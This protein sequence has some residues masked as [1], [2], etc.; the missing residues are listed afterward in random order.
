MKTVWPLGAQ[1]QVQ[2]CGSSHCSLQARSSCVWSA[3]EQDQTDC[4]PPDSQ[5]SGQ[6]ASQPDLSQAARAS[7][8]LEPLK[9]SPPVALRFPPCTTA[10]RTN[11]SSIIISVACR[12][13]SVVFR[14]RANKIPGRPIVCFHA[15]ARSSARRGEIPAGQ[16]E[17]DQSSLVSLDSPASQAS[18]PELA[19]V[20]KPKP[21]IRRSLGRA[22]RRLSC[23][24]CLASRR[25]FARPHW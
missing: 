22:R 23:S 12:R 24:E 4:E 21:E 1:G 5:H 6:P 20:C 10:G 17:R 16:V 9:L 25:P 11:S 13:R 14:G 3:A 18:K 2:A 19:A 7:S 8:A 15:N